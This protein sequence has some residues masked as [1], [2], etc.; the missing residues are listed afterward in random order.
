[1]RVYYD[2]DADLNFIKSKKVAIIGFGSQ[3]HAHALN[4]RDCGVTDVVIAS[5]PGA[6]AKKAEAAGFALN[7]GFAG[8]SDFDAAGDFAADF[9]S[10]LTAPGT[11]H[12]IMCHPGRVDAELARLD[13]VT[14][15]RE[16]A[17]GRHRK[18]TSDALISR[19]RSAGSF[20]RSARSNADSTR[21]RISVA[22]S[23][24]FSPGARSSHSL[25]PK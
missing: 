5:R 17:S 7:D 20:E 4:M 16:A 21:R 25:C 23:I 8:F 19:A 14:A 3:G 24:V 2:R 13:P 1:M 11:R 15:S 6:S 18:V 12:L 10:Y 22:S 9:A